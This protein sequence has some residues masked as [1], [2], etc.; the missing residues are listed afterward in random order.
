MSRQVYSN[1]NFKIYKS[2]NSGY[3][4][5]NKNKE[6]ETGHTHIN[7]FKMAKYIVKLAVH[8]I[9]PKHLSDY[10]LISLVRISSNKKYKEE[11]LSLLNDKNSKEYLKYVG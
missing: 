1:R 11:I 5:H 2:G 4:I 7:D 6:F 10:L 3:I 8:E 9:I